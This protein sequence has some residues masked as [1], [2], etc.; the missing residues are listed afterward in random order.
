MLWQ[1]VVDEGPGRPEGTQ[2]L[3]C[4]DETDVKGRRGAEVGRRHPHADDER[5][6]DE[7]RGDFLGG[8]AKRLARGS[9]V[10]GRRIWLFYSPK[11]SPRE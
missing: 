11:R 6:G 5:L 9:A 3:K 2:G 4:F 7:Q 10:T 8:G 1:Q